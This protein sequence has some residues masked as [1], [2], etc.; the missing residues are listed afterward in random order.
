MAAKIYIF[1]AGSRDMVGL[2][3]HLN[4][5]LQGAGEVIYD[6]DEHTGPNWN[7]DVLLYYDADLEAWI[8]RLASF[9]EQWGV[10]DSILSFTIIKN[11]LSNGNLTIESKWENRQIEFAPKYFSQSF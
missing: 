6:R 3:R 1:G 2:S 7:V 8:Q 10:W 5:L 9:F 4:D 11:V